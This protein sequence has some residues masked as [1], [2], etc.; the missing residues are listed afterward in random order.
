MTRFIWLDTE[1]QAASSRSSPASLFVDL[2]KGEKKSRYLQFSVLD[3]LPSFGIRREERWYTGFFTQIMESEQI[4]VES[5]SCRKVSYRFTVVAGSA[6]KR[7]FYLV[8]ASL[9]D[10]WLNVGY[11]KLTSEYVETGKI[12]T[13]SLESFQG[14]KIV[15][16]H[17]GKTNGV[18]SSA[19][20][21]AEILRMKALLIVRNNFFVVFQ[22]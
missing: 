16:E 7:E 13:S 15:E 11:E 4:L 10:G 22:I 14:M 9:I 2:C 18:L 21:F 20:R 19:E 8:S 3:S 12:M 17:P 1:A 5:I 6:A